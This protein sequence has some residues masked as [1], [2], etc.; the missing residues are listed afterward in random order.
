MDEADL[1][2]SVKIVPAGVL[3]LIALQAAGYAYIKP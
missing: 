1:P 3:D 2:A